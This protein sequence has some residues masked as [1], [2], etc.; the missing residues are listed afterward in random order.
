MLTD[1]FFLS[2][3]GSDATAD[4]ACRGQCRET[5]RTLVAVRAISAVP[6]KSAVRLLSGRPDDPERARVLEL[7]LLKPVGGLFDSAA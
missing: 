4:A 1:M 3:V 6:P 5:G 2:K 7:Q